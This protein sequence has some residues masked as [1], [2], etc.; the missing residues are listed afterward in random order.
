MNGQPIFRI[1]AQRTVGDLVA[2]MIFEVDSHSY[3]PHALEARFET[4]ERGVD[5]RLVE[6]RMDLGPGVVSFGAGDFTPDVPISNLGDEPNRPS[7][8]HLARRKESTRSEGDLVSEEIKIQYA[9]HRVGACRGEA[10]QMRRDLHGNLVVEGQVGS[11]ER[12]AQLLAVLGPFRNSA[13]AEIR[14]QTV[15]EPFAAHGLLAQRGLNPNGSASSLVPSTRAVELT[16]EEFPA[17]EQLERYFERLQAESSISG[18][19]IDQTSIL[20][21]VINLS[22]RALE[23]SD[24]SL[25]DAWALR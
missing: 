13:L 19:A 12:K 4:P 2:T 25:I 20:R 11:L 22:N 16:N 8:S 7:D 1:R 17:R 3:R 21:Q 14:I 15:E 23:L 9:L 10:I 5:L 6:R 18:H 24:A